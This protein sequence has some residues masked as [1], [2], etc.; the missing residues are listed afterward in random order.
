VTVG[1][2]LLP[3]ARGHGLATRAV[4]LVVTWAFDA[5]SVAEVGLRAAPANAASRGVAERAGFRLVE[6]TIE[7]VRY[8]QVRP[9]D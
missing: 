5:L 6:S 7:T 1:Y 2:W 9:R 8:R 3:E 4:R